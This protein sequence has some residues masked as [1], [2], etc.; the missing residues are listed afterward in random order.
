M[1][2]PLT[3]DDEAGLPLTDR[4]AVERTRLANERTAL[5]Y[6]RTAFG[7]VAGALT[8]LHVYTG[9]VPDVA[10]VALSAL[11]LAALAVGGLRYRAAA[12]LIRTDVRRSDTPAEPTDLPDT[13]HALTP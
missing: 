4:L 10:A 2:P 1:T 6:V 5:A 7:L 11:G 8:I 13:T 9:A 12:R 3:P